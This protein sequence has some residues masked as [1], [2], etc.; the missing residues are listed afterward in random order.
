[1]LAKETLFEL[2]AQMLSYFQDNKIVPRD[3]PA[4]TKMRLRT[5]GQRAA[6][7]A[8][9]GAYDSSPGG[10]GG[11]GGA[12]SAPPAESGSNGVPL[13]G[14]VEPFVRGAQLRADPSL[15]NVTVPPGVLGGQRVLVDTP[16]GLELAIQVLP[17]AHTRAR[18][19]GIFFKSVFVL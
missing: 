17:Q 18:V 19:Q 10:G 11:G 15:M 4:T 9:G 16:G 14:V 12:P 13:S 3:K 6:A 1:L 8:L 5:D 7:A 2:P